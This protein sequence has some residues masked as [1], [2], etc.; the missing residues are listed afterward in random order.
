MVHILCASTKHCMQCMK[1]SFKNWNVVKNNTGYLFCIIEKENFLQAPHPIIV[2][3][4]NQLSM[5][6]YIEWNWVRHYYFLQLNYR[7]VWI[8]MW[9]IGKNTEPSQHTHAFHEEMPM[10]RWYWRCTGIFST[11]LWTM[12]Q[13]KA[14]LE[15]AK[16]F[17][18][19]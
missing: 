8:L 7:T 17:V 10:N 18:N 2:L 14:A 19:K 9:Y 4:N 11:C 13:S 1:N 3:W 5:I 6:S 12:H 15:L 16:L